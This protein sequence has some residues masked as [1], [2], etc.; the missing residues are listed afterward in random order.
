[1]RKIALSEIDSFGRSEQRMSYC[2]FLN[3][4]GP[5]SAN[6]NNEFIKVTPAQADALHTFLKAMNNPDVIVKFPEWRTLTLGDVQISAVGDRHPMV[7]PMKEQDITV[8]HYRQWAKEIIRRSMN[9]S[10]MEVIRLPNAGFLSVTGDWA[11]YPRAN[12]FVLAYLRPEMSD[13]APPT[14]VVAL[15]ERLRKIAKSELVKDGE[16]VLKSDGFHCDLGPIT[17]AELIYIAES[18]LPRQ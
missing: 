15:G 11:L 13:A 1:M 3:S 7:Q 9:I 18:I 4:K 14:N 17:N 12:D 6:G 16:L 5:D 8:E 10:F 2:I